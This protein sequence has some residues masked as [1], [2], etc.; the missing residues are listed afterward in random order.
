MGN[1]SRDQCL[2]EDKQCH[3]QGYQEEQSEAEVWDVCLPCKWEREKEIDT[4]RQRNCRE[5]WLI[6]YKHQKM[7]VCALLSLSVL[8]A[9]AQTTYMEMEQ[10]T[11]NDQVTTV[12]T[13]SEPIRFVD[14]STDK[15]VGEIG[16]SFSNIWSDACPVNKRIGK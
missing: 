8:S 6:E 4:A 15:V 14:I 11:V 9:K 7:N 5:R 10:L 3:Q 16:S 12:I 1:A 13:A 2:P